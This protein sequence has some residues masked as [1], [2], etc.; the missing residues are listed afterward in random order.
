VGEAAAAAWAWTGT[1]SLRGARGGRSLV[2]RPWRSALERLPEQRRGGAEKNPET[3]LHILDL[4]LYV[5]R[6]SITL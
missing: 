5:G 3:S 6:H 2:G 4:Y 1:A